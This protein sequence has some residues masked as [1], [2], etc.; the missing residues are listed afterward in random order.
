MSIELIILL[1]NVASTLFMVGLIWF[2]QIVHYPLM[3]GV[4]TEG[5]EEYQER[6]Q[7]KTTLVVGPP[8][9]VE[10]FT[11]VLLIWFPPIHNAP[12]LL[13]G[14]ALLFIIWGSTVF[15]QIPCHGRL[16]RGFD[17]KAYWHL[18]VTNW[19]RTVCWTLRGLLV[20]WIVAEHIRLAGL[21]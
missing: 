20:C 17:A 18:V 13:L 15:L 7:K 21:T 5:Y 3:N 6:H 19:L 14:V 8:M 2:V 1:L 4:G 10:A 9:I 11:S 16:I 12:L